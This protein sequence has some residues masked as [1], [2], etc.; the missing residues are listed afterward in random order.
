VGVLL[1]VYFLLTGFASIG[2]SLVLRPLGGWVWMMLNGVLSI[3]L[4]VVFLAGW[5]FSSAALI[6]ILVGISFVFD[7]ISLLAVSSAM[8]ARQE[9]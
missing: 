3:I 5:P 9:P 1:V 6:G 4:A 7:G 8:K 2:F